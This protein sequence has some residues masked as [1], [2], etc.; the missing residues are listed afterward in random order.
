MI[1]SFELGL[2]FWH[3][4]YWESLSTQEAEG[5]EVVE[6]RRSCTIQCSE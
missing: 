5:E 6:D 1:M 3:S 2:E 4:S